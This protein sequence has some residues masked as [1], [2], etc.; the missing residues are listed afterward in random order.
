[1][2]YCPL[3]NTPACRVHSRDE[4]T[5]QDLPVAHFCL[6]I[7]LSVCKFFCLND[8]CPR[9]IFT[10]RLAAVVAPWARRT[11]RFTKCLKEIGLA[12]GGAAARLSVQMGYG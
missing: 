11:V 2:A 10:E 4:R 3:C 12:L 5:L 9:Q 6:K 7:I 1:M 8:T